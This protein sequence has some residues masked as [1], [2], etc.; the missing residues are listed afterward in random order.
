MKNGASNN[1]QPRTCFEYVARAQKELK[2]H[3]TKAN[4]DFA[5]PFLKGIEVMVLA[6]RIETASDP[7]L[8]S[9]IDIAARGTGIP[10]EAV[11]AYAEMAIAMNQPVHIY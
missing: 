6:Q 7:A 8:G 10:K 1:S 3:L 5:L 11:N 9:M 4:S 2:P